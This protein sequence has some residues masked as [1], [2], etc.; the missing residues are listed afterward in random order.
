MLKYSIFLTQVKG[1]KITK[2]NIAI[3]NE[4]TIFTKINEINLK[5]K[6]ISEDFL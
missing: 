5:T 4:Q 2:Q 6:G 3:N 1:V